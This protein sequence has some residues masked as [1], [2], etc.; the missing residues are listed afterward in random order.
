[1]EMKKVHIKAAGFFSV[2]KAYPEVTYAQGEGMLLE[3]GII[4]LF[5]QLGHHFSW[6]KRGGKRRIPGNIYAF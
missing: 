2:I 3:G 6:Q 1:M 4:K 5:F